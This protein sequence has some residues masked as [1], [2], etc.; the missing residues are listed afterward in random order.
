MKDLTKIVII[1]DK[2]ASMEFSSKKAIEGFNEF[3]KSQEL[4]VGESVVS[5]Y[6]FANELEETYLNV[7]T[8]SGQSKYL[9]L[10]EGNN[11]FRKTIGYYPYRANGMSTSLRDAI[12][13]V[14]VNTGKELSNLEESERPNKVIVLIIT[15]GADNSSK[16]F[17]LNE[18]KQLITHQQD[19]YNWTFLYL[20]EDITN[21]KEAKA[22][23]I[24]INTV[25]SYQGNENI[26]A[27][28]RA[29]AFYTN[30]VRSG[31]KA[32]DIDL[33]DMVNKELKNG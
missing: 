24:S 23:G 20:G 4:S 13:T 25:A 7:P 5:L 15:D 10:L 17:S 2:S 18:I 16:K 32:I 8:R 3:I 26:G 28:F 12:G 33:H 1:L 27:G 30:K 14:I 9:Q 19:V 31:T 6:Q 11:F 21:A 22:M 29:A